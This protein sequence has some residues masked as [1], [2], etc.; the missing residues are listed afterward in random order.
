MASTSYRS[1]TIVGMTEPSDGQTSEPDPSERSGLKNPV[2]AV[3]AMGASV[4]ALEFIVLLL[5]L[6]PLRMLGVQP[7]G[8]TLGITLGCAVVCLILASRMKHEWAWTGIGVLQVV[9]LVAGL[10]HWMLAAVGIV[11]GVTWLYA[12]S[13]KRQLSRPPV[14]DTDG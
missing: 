10:L 12:M 1:A 2:R 8:L 3:R 7:W 13:V 4:V 14:R 6:L 11:F 9:L 5:A